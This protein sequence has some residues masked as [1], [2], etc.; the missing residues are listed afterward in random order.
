MSSE[1]F[2]NHVTSTAFNLTLSKAM[3]ETLSYLDQ[4]QAQQGIGLCKFM[5][6]WGLKDRGLV[7]P[8][9][10]IDRAQHYCM[11]RLTETGR[12]VIP[13]LKAAGLYKTQYVGAPPVDIPP[14]EVTIKKRQDPAVHPS[15]EPRVT[16]KKKPT[17][18]A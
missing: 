15:D 13:L 9:G 16:F 8:V 1:A 11:V 2:K 7:E 17:D 12:L 3:I 18:A 14:V 5:T 6:Y 10:D 4:S